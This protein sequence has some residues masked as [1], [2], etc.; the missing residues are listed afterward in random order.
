VWSAD[1]P[2]PLAESLL[3]VLPLSAESPVFAA[4]TALLAPVNNAT[5]I[6]HAAR[7]VST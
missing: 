4:D 1:L 6:A 2:V 3:W 5:A 7:C